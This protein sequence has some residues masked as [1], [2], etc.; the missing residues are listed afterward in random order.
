[1]RNSFIVTF[2]VSKRVYYT[3]YHADQ[4][5]RALRLNGTPCELTEVRHAQEKDA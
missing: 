2:G 1:M 3:Y 5:M 4:M